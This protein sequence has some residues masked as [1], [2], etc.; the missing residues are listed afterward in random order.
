[1]KS[2]W[3]KA[4]TSYIAFEEL[5]DRLPVKYILL[6]YSNESL[7]A[8]QELETILKKYKSYKVHMV[9]YKRNIMSQIGNAESIEDPNTANVEYIILIEKSP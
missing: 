5:F 7:I 4:Q 3:N 6:S 8:L 2:E 1:M 9:D